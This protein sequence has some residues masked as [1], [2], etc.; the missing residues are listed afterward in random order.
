[1]ANL[2]TKTGDKGQTSLAGGVRVSKND[3]HVWCY[4][5]VDEANSMLGLAYAQSDQAYVRE[6]L[7]K[8]QGRLFALGAELASDKTGAASFHGQIGE[9]DVAFLERVVDTC[10]ETTGKQTHFVIPGVDQASASLHVAR[11]MVRRAERHMVALGETEEIREVLVRY[12]NR[13]S[14]AVYALARL[15]EELARRGALE[16]QVTDLVREKLSAALGEAPP[17]SLD[18]AQE[19]ARRARERAQVLGVSIV[20]AAVDEGGNLI[21]AQRMEGALLGSVDVAMGK[22][23]T[24]NAFQLPTH[25][26]GQASRPEGPLFGID[27]ATPG[28]IVLFGGGFPYTVGGKVVGGVGISGGTVEQDMEIARWAMAHHSQAKEESANA[29]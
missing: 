3:L 29:N 26:L 25:T 17:L 19:M 24:A 12:V 15:Q 28:K 5:T 27:S 4:G 21:L 8:I 6:S 9:E 18:R 2:Y 16:R 14:D 22:A 7:R 20:F 11:T 10:T 1:M 23:Y 13:L